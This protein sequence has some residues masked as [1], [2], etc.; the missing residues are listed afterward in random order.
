MVNNTLAAYCNQLLLV[1][2][3]RNY[4]LIDRS[5]IYTEETILGKNLV[6][7]INIL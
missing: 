2:Y 7:S 1:F 4:T 5:L 6:K 3:N